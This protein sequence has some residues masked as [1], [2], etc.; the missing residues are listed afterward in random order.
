MNE[1]DKT[2]ISILAA[3]DAVWRPMRRADWNAPAP[4]NLWEARERFE[5]RGVVWTTSGSEAERKRSQRS[6]EQL[7][8]DGMLN[9]RGSNKGHG[10]RLTDKGDIFARALCGAPNVDAGHSSLSEVIQLA[11]QVNQDGAVNGAR[12]T[13]EL[14]LARLKNYSDTDDCRNKLWAVQT[15]MLAALWR[16][17]VVSL[18]DCEGR[19]YYY[20][21]EAGYATAKLPRPAL[22]VDIPEYDDSADELYHAATIAAR[23]MLRS[24]KPT[25]PNEIGYI[26]LPCSLDLRRPRTRKGKQ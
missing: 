14:W 2:L 26:S 6:L 4:A 19:V 13:S 25:R 21:T 22:P 3:S 15:M 1:Q 10:V 11:R 23:S 16:G 9:L 8:F 18:S 12:L 24:A 17:W 5:A 20:S 7:S